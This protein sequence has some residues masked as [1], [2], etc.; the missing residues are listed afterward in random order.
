[1]TPAPTENPSSRWRAAAPLALLILALLISWSWRTLHGGFEPV[2]EP[3][4]ESYLTAPLD[5]S[6]SRSLSYYRTIG[7]PW[8]L[9][10]AGQLAPQHAAVPYLH[11]LFYSLGCIG[12]FFGVRRFTSS[13]NIALIAALPLPF[14]LTTRFTASLLTESVATS[15]TLLAT[16]AVFA[17]CSE[18]RSAWLWP[19][20]AVLVFS[21]IQVRPTTQWLVVWVPLAV[22]LLS[23]RN[24]NRRR[25]PSIAAAALATVV[26]WLLFATLRLVTVGHFGLVSF[27][28]TNLAAISTFL[29]DQ[30]A[31][32]QLADDVRPTA[33]LI[34][35][36]R[37][38]NHW[39]QLR[40]GADAREWFPYYNR[41]L[42]R[43]SV[44]STSWHMNRDLERGQVTQAEDLWGTSFAV[45]RDRRLQ[46]IAVGVIQQ[47]PG[48][49]LSWILGAIRYGLEGLIRQPT[50]IISLLFTLAALGWR[51]F[52]KSK[53]L[54]P[55]IATGRAARATPLGVACLAH[56]AGALVLVSM[57]SFPMLRYLSEI[58]LLL[59]SALLLLAI[60]LA[61]PVTTN[62]RP[63]TTQTSN[64]AS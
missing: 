18:R 27:A 12:F 51:R 22:A 54:P 19:A 33:R 47:R 63:A 29:V 6:W 13:P 56:G 11:T 34:L 3:D 23:W 2:V 62:R 20:L 14:A 4:T 38:R 8:F 5:G 7:Y 41:S 21:A 35:K 43:V 26:P 55:D 16:G 58:I 57:T 28:G 64:P 10:I 46:S 50:V 17:L 53:T 31:I 9:R 1:M 32:T 59:P 44:R 49:Y 60:A 52:G 45:E 36:R 37:D 48:G 42:W 25:W 39:P 40:W 24:P 30:Q 15:L 61:T